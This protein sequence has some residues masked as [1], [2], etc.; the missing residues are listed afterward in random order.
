MPFSKEIRHKNTQ[1]SLEK[2]FN[3]INR[4]WKKVKGCV[5]IIKIFTSETKKQKRQNE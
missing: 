3:I 5:I 2:R 4:I 1:V